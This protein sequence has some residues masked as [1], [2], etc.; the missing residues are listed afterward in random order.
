VRLWLLP[1]TRGDAY[2]RR[3]I[4]RR[5]VRVHPRP[6]DRLVAR[7]AVHVVWPPAVSEAG[8]MTDQHLPGAKTVAIWAAGRPRN[9]GR[10]VSKRRSEARAPTDSRIGPAVLDPHRV[11][12]R[13]MLLAVDA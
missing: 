8:L 3:A 4:E 13:R 12:G 9:S 7:A 5:A 10:R 2:R 11:A 1:A 6:V